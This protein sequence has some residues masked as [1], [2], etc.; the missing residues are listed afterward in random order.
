MMIGGVT[1]WLDEGFNTYMASKATDHSLGPEAW[2]RR[3]FGVG[4]GR[5]GRLGRLS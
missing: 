5:G 1:G 4:S 2:G 3:Y